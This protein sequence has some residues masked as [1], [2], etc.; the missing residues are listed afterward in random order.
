MSG[1]QEQVFDEVLV[2]CL[3]ANDT[4]S[5]TVLALISHE[6]CPFH[7]VQVRQRKYACFLINQVF[8]VDF[9]GVCHQLGTTGVC[10]FCFDILHFIAD[11]AKEFGFVR[12]QGFII[13]DFFLQIF[14][15][16]VDFFVFQALQ[17]AQLHFQNGLCLN[18]RQTKA[19]H[20]TFLCIIVAGTDDTDDF[21]NI[22]NGN[23]QPFQNMGAFFRLIQI[24]FCPAGHHFFL[25]FQV[26]RQ[27]LLE[28]QHRRLAVYQSNH[29]GAEAFLKL[30][31][32]IKL[33]QDNVRVYV[34]FQFDDNLNIIAGGSVV[35]I[36]DAIHTFFFDQFGN[37]FNQTEFIDHVRDF[38]Y[39]DF[40]SAVAHGL[41]FRC[42]THKDF[43][44]SGTICGADA[45]FA[46]NGGTGGEVR[47]FDIFHQFF[48]IGFFAIDFIIYHDS[49]TV[50]DFSQIMRR[51]IGCH[52][53]GD[54]R[55]T[56][57]QQVWNPCRQYHRF[58]FRFVVVR[59]KIHRIFFDVRQHG[60]CHLGH[61]GFGVTGCRCAVAV[62]GA[63]VPMTVYQHI[64]HGEI[65]CHT[66]HCL[67]DGAVAV[68]VVFTH[69]IT[70]DTGGLFIGFIRLQIHFV[71][72][73]ENSSL[74]RL[75]TVTDIGQCSGY[76]NAHGVVDVALFH[77]LVDVYGNDLIHLVVYFTHGFT[78]IPFIRSPFP[79]T[80]RFPR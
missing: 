19:F 5:A 38:R 22:G 32:F 57:H 3:H 58:F 75:Q 7:I 28:I 17:S 8:H 1:A 63:K 53:N 15:F 24:E 76:D 12:Q 56:V 60:C 65:L 31:I 36:A 20:Q 25:M 71:H 79:H 77:F 62:N 4:T 10:V 21:V 64:A 16:R 66:H 70:S 52:T 40:F 44:A 72:G 39:D 18:F 9:A 41:D 35:Q 45:A 26:F 2:P 14:I 11:N 68:G 51:D 46:Q 30:G 69:G 47:T 6:R 33:I 59:H 67:I 61:T 23:P 74:Y 73:V 80:A 37:L 55:G 42:G 49:Q 34:F 43:P 50:D 48:H 27:H 13:S 29:D 54:T 78:S